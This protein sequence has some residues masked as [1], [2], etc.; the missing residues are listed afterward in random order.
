[1]ARRKSEREP[2]PDRDPGMT[3]E[4]ISERMERGLRRAFSTPSQPHGRSPREAAPPRRRKE[5]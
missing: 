4:E 1:M 2:E 3:D 5:K